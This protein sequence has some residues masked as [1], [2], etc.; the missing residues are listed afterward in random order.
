MKR[1]FGMFGSSW[2]KSATTAFYTLG[3]TV[4]LASCAPAAQE[5]PPAVA[6]GTPQ[7]D[8]PAA[9][10]GASVLQGVFTARQA[11]RGEQIFQQ[12]CTAC[13]STREFGVA[14][15]RRWANGSLGDLFDFL[16][17]TMPQTNPGSLS[18]QEYTEVITYFL[19]LNGYPQGTDDLS[20]DELHS[21]TMEQMPA[22]ATR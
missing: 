9:A 11:S 19:R 20:A 18:S 13:H 7:R 12:N 10:G 17:A 21:V 6:G 16:R 4:L 3:S 22:G 15:Q 14:F 2:K 5:A 8:A 1:R